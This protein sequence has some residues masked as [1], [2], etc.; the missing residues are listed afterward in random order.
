[1]VASMAVT[2]AVP[3]A[4][5]L[6]RPWSWPGRRVRGGKGASSLACHYGPRN[7]E[8]PGNH[9]FSLKNVTGSK[10]THKALSTVE[11]GSRRYCTDSKMT[12]T[13]F[14]QLHIS[15]ASMLLY[16][17]LLGTDIDPNILCAPPQL[18]NSAVIVSGRTRGLNANT[19]AVCALYRV[20]RVN[21]ETPA[22][23]NSSEAPATPVVTTR[24][25]TAET[26]R[27]ARR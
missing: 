5:E 23:R 20:R 21:D 11:R 9:P 27:S 17:W 22:E 24:S 26:C 14:V 4:G 12:T 7:Q 8:N 6:V 15:L 19:R 3:S 2:R 1:M 25:S 18:N 13:T 16:F 10:R